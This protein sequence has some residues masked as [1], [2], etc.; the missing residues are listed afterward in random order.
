[1]PCSRFFA[2][3]WWCAPVPLA[4]AKVGKSASRPHIVFQ[5]FAAVRL[6]RKGHARKSVP[7]EGIWC[8]NRRIQGDFK[9]YWMENEEI[10]KYF[11]GN[12]FAITVIISS[13]TL[14]TPMLQG[15]K[16]CQPRLECGDSRGFLQPW[17]WR[18]PRSC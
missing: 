8:A 16:G 14:I 17:I 2:K 15:S 18:L 4:P 5:L 12:I 11:V 1:M 3:S 9:Y 7:S 13:N 6:R 10:R